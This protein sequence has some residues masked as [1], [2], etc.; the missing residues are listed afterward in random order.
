MLF[1]FDAKL[2][3]IN[4]LDKL[5]Y[6]FMNVQLFENYIFMNVQLFK[7]H[8]FM[9]VQLFENHIFMNIQW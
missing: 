6:I 7:N 1:L 3:I 9:N 8:I 4:H 2:L 5:N